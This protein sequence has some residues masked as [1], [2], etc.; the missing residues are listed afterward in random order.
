MPSTTEDAQDVPALAA[1]L[2]ASIGTRRYMR[3]FGGRDQGSA[4]H[5]ISA[6]RLMSPITSLACRLARC[7]CVAVAM[8]DRLSA[9]LAEDVA[10]EARRAGLSERI[11]NLTYSDPGTRNRGGLV[12]R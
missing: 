8:A 7:F 6:E 1:I 2:A 10:R 4:G 9:L 11:T 12:V 3:R 5:G